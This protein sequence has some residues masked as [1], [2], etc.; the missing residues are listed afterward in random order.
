MLR[1]KIKPNVY[2]ISL[3]SIGHFAVDLYPAFIVGVIPLI[4]VKFDLSLFQVSLLTAISQISNSLTQ[5][6][7]GYLS[8]KHGVKN[9]F[10]YGIFSAAVFLSLIAIMPN[11]FVVLILLFL[12]NLGVSAFHPP[13]A[14]IGA[15]YRGKKKGFGNSIIALGGNIGYSVGS[16]FFI[17]IIDKIGIKFSPFAMIPGILIAIFLLKSFS[18]YDKKKKLSRNVSQKTGADSTKFI[19]AKLLHIF[20]VWLAAFSRDLT[21]MGLLT[22]MPL[23]F[24]NL[25]IN[26][27]NISIIL[28][29]FG[30]IGGIGGVFS[31]YFA[32][33]LK[34]SVLIQIAYLAIIPL[35]YFIFKTYAPVNIILFILTGFFLISTVPL[36]ISLSHEIFPKNL[37]LASSLVI[38]FSSGF[39]GITM[40]FIGKLADKIGIERTIHIMLIL[41]VVAI[42]AM[43]F[44]PY[45]ERKRLQG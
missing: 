19:K 21:W 23:Y 13:S 10:F 31:S 14:A 17:S 38:G 25:K 6:L 4:A 45:A 37:S 39:A 18:V 32:D 28:L 36:C 7:F 42:M 1:E 2:N 35:I 15:E 16:L 40:M 8:D 24:T 29:I 26:V 11:Y 20:L 5:P 12:G 43:F 33:R 22:F 44:M 9:Y 27:I 41:P 3:S 30:F 34:R